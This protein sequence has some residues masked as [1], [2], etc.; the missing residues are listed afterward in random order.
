MNTQAETMLA[1]SRRLARVGAGER[2]RILDQLRARGIDFKLLPIPP[3]ADQ[4]PRVTASY[5]QSR[6][7]FMWRLE[8][9]SPAYNMSSALELEGP[10]DERVLG[11]TFDAL[12]QRHEALRTL[13]VPAA[14]GQPLQSIHAHQPLALSVEE[15]SHLRGRERDER[16]RELVRLTAEQQF[17]L[18][19]GPLFRVRLIRLE[20]ERH[21]LVVAMHHVISDGWSM[22]VIIED[23]GR[24]YAQIAAGAAP[25]L[26]ALPV[27]YADYSAWQ[28]D[29]LEAG[30]GDRQ[31]A[32][33]KRALGSTQ[34]LLELPS[35]RPRPLAPS[36]RGGEHKVA[37]GFEPTVTFSSH[38]L[39]HKQLDGAVREFLAR[40]REAVNEHVAAARADGVLRPFEHADLP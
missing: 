1:L 22:N 7:W 6:L 4:G 15:V 29:F 39:R 36:Y 16:V 8:P 2:Q 38:F 20:A 21:V 30:E 32:Y 40:E 24:L 27:Q 35:D 28:R 25:T 13:F 11:R 23:F 18:V 12:I 26:P 10:L 19:R 31:L 34:P 37:R 3:R 5:A 14:D 9:N 17:D 33:W